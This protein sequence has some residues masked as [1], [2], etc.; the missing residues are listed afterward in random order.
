[1]D[2]GLWILQF[3]IDSVD[4]NCDMSFIDIREHIKYLKFGYGATDQLNIEIRSGHITRA[5]ALD[6]ALKIDGDVSEENIK[7]FVSI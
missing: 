4:E 1:M 7:D 6:K 5:E 3:W 2:G